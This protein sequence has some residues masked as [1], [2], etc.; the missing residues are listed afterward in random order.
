MIPV[1]AVEN[2]SVVVCWV[3]CLASIRTGACAATVQ[4]DRSVL[5]SHAAHAVVVHASLPMIDANEKMGEEGV[6]HV[7]ITEKGE[8]IG[9]VSAPD[10]LAYYLKMFRFMQ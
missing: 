7:S 9:V 10:L 6:R 2:R 3:T 8:I 4:A 5:F 1:H